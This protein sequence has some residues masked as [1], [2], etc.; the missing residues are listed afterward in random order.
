VLDIIYGQIKG[1]KASVGGYFG[2]YYHVDIDLK[3]LK[4]TWLFKEGGS[5]KNQYKI[6]PK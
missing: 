1:L 4:T 3:N 6:H 2:G 5:E